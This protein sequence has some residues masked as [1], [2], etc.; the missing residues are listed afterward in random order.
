MEVSPGLKPDP[1][2]ITLVPQGP[3]VLDKLTA[4]PPVIVN[5]AEAD[6]VGKEKRPTLA[7]PW[8]SIVYFPGGKGRDPS[9]ALIMHLICFRSVGIAQKY[10]EFVFRIP[11]SQ[12][13]DPAPLAKQ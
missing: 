11:Y 5:G 3:E 1:L 4:G 12:E 6:C 8:T 13:K 9:A 7:S 10:S 2:A